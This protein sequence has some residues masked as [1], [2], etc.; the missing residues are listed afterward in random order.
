VFNQQE[1]LAII[2]VCDHAIKEGGIE[3]AEIA[4]PLVFKCRQTLVQSQQGQG[5]QAPQ[6]VRQQEKGN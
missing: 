2:K 1:L 4:M 5:Q 6:L 3:V